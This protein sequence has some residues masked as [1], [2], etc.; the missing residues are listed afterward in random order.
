MANLVGNGALERRIRG[1]GV[2]TGSGRR[3]SHT[4]CGGCFNFKFEA[5][6]DPAVTPPAMILT[7][8]PSFASR[9]APRAAYVE[10]RG[11]KY[12]AQFSRDP[13]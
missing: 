2:T 10:A 6:V 7:I 13:G 12:R 4:S 3:W 5:F 9:S 1:L 8:R 11:G